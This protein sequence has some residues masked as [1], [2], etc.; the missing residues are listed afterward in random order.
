MSVLKKINKEIKIVDV[1]REYGL[2][3]TEGTFG[4]FSHRCKCPSKKHKSGSER[5]ESLYIDEEANTFYC[6]GCSE[7]YLS[8]NFYMACEDCDFHTA[9]S[10]L[11]ERVQYIPSEDGYIQKTSNSDILLEISDVMRE[12]IQ[13]N[14]GEL[15]YY[16]NFS[17]QVDDK[18]SKLDK[19]D[20]LNAVKLLDSIRKHLKNRSNK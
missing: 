2:S 5:T 10:H 9:L 4:A 17:Q 1:A 7:G 12:Y 18:I 11:R 13:N 14:R 15:N 16:L 6:F 20:I 8:I 3:L 19:Y